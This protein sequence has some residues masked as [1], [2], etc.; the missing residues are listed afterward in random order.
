MIGIGLFDRLVG[1]QWIFCLL[2]T[3]FTLSTADDRILM[4][5]PELYH[6]GRDGYWF[7]LPSFILY[8]L[9]GIYQVYLL[10]PL[11]VPTDCVVVRGHLFPH[12]VH[13]YHDYVT[14]GRN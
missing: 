11:A 7:G 14:P 3:F 4:D 6:H 5:I 8:M 10:P 1:M 2:V 12:S 9:D 13:L